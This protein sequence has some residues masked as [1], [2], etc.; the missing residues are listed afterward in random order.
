MYLDTSLTFEQMIIRVA[1]ALRMASYVNPDNSSDVTDNQA[2]IPRDRNRLDIC[3]RA[4]NDA[5]DELHAAKPQGWRC[6][7]RTVEFT[8]S[9]DGTGPDSIATDPGRI[10]LPLGVQG[11]PIG[12]WT[13]G[14]AGQYGGELTDCHEDAVRGRYLSTSG[15]DWTGYPRLICVRPFHDVGISPGGDRR[16]WEAYVWPRPDQAYTLSARFNLMHRKMVELSERHVFG[17]LHDQNI[18]DLAIA[19][20]KARFGPP[21]EKAM[22]R[23]DA[24]D[25]VARSIALDNVTEARTLGVT[26]DAV[27]DGAIDC[28]GTRT[29]HDRVFLDGVQVI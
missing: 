8:M 22:H 15:S 17:A 5:L 23:Q 6:L 4:V 24:I 2:R 12:K 28:G 13:W 26:E 19:R 7:R 14:L 10:R 20:H 1:E 16:G 27:V 3:K 9:T 18:I 29:R 11:P 21:G 25:A